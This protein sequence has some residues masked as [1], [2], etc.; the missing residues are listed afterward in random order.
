MRGNVVVRRKNENPTKAQLTEWLSDVNLRDVS[1][2]A[3]RL[4]EHMPCNCDL[5]K[6]QPFIN[7]GHTLVCRINKR[8]HQI[9]SFGI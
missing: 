7:T 9:R 2:V 8:A 4:S 1:A 5:D 6:W 3:K